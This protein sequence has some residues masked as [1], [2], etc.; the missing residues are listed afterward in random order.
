MPHLI[1]GKLLVS[2][3][4]K[5]EPIDTEPSKFISYIKDLC[6]LQQKFTLSGFYH[7][8][9]GF[10]DHFNYGYTK[11]CELVLLDWG[12]NGFLYFD[13]TIC[14]FI[15][16]QRRNLIQYSEKFAKVTLL[17]HLLIFGLG[18]CQYSYLATFSQDASGYELSVLLDFIC[19]L[20]KG[21]YLNPLV[22]DI[23][24]NQLCNPDSWAILKNSCQSISNNSEPLVLEQADILDV[25]LTPD[26][27][28]VSGYQTYSI[29]NNVLSWF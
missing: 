9:L 16:I 17:L 20:F 12:G 15:P 11:D 6:L 19:D 1:Y 14:P 22:D 7:W 25:K 3:I 26:K 2:N 29:I 24:S 13:S 10:S 21:S 28:E 18:K 23:L 8:D 4:G 5:C 27:V